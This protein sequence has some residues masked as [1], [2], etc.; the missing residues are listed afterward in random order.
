MDRASTT[1]A[2]EHLWQRGAGPLRSELGDACWRMWLEGVCPIGF[3]DG[4]LRL[5]VPSTLARQRIE[6]TYGA[7]IQDVLFEETGVEVDLDLV[8]LTEPRTGPALVAPPDLPPAVEDGAK[9]VVNLRDESRGSESGHALTPRYTF[10]QF[11][12]GA[13]NRFAHAAALS[14]AEKPARSYNPLFIYGQSGLGKTHLL[15]AIGHH[16]AHMFP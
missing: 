6:A 2:A 10:E 16:V 5:A 3:E 9:P 13:S 15:H 1:E 7:A 8:V 12:I 11:V 14:V 4:V